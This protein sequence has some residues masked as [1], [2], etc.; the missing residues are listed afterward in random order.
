MDDKYKVYLLSDKWKTIK[1]KILAKY[2]NRCVFCG[3][4]NKLQV[5]HLSYKHI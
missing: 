4:D 5:H 3:S 1:N 2:N